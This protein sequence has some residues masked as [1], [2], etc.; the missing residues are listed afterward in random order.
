[1]KKHRQP[2]IGYF[3]KMKG[4]S[5]SPLKV[6]VSEIAWSWIGAFLGIATVSYINYNMLE[7]TDFVLVI[8]SFGHLRF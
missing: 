6:S 7:D 4:T 5:K 3:S 2:Q 1:M 8:G